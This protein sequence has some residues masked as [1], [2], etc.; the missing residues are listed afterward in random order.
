MKRGSYP[1]P[2]SWEDQVN[3][4]FYILRSFSYNFTQRCW[5]GRRGAAVE[6][7]PLCFKLSTEKCRDSASMDSRAQK[8][9][10]RCLGLSGP[11]QAR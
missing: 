10:W 3:R 5:A 6:S 8:D 7:P 11:C 9:R 1:P 2:S 4:N